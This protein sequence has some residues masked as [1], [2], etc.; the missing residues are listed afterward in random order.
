M[1]VILRY[2]GVGRNKLAQFR[3]KL[4]KPPQPHCRTRRGANRLRFREKRFAPLVPA[5]LKRLGGRERHVKLK[6]LSR[7]FKRFKG[8]KRLR[9][10]LRSDPLPAATASDLPR[11]A[12]EVTERNILDRQRGSIIR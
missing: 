9:R 1:A 3:Q 6:P 7:G 4:P 2:N 5:Y 12:G 8:G 11:C 10:N